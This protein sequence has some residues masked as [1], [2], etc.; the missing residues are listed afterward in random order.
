ML[1]FLDYETFSCVDIKAGVYAY[2]ECPTFEALMCAWAIDGGPVQVATGETEIAT[3]PGLFDPAV[4]KVAHNAQFER[5]VTSRLAGGTFLSPAAWFDTAALAAE[6]GYSRALAPL[7]KVLGCV[8]KDT[9]GTRLINR[10]CK[11]YR[12]G[13]VTAGDDPDRWAAFVDYCKQDVETLREVF[14]RLPPWPSGERELYNVD[15][16][17]NDRGITVDVALAKAAVT[18]DGR[19]RTA[20]RAELRQITGVV[21]PGS[22][23]Q[24]RGWFE[25]TGLPLSNLRAATVAE[26]LTDPGLSPEHRRALALRQHLALAASRKYEAAIRATNADGRFRGGFHFFGAHTGRWAGRG[27]QL[28]NLPR[29]EVSEGA[30][31]RLLTDGEATPEELKGL[32]RSLLVGPFTVV[33]YSAIE[34]RV[35]AWL[36]GESWVLE[37]FREDRDIYVATAERMSTPGNTLTRQQGKVATLALGYQGAVNSLRAMGA[38][39]ED[40][41]LVS[42]VRQWRRANPAIV[43]YW[44]AT[45]TR[46]ADKAATSQTV[47]MPLPSG[48][49][50]SYHGVRWET[51]PVLGSATGAK[52]WKEG[53]RYTDPR[54]PSSRAARVGTYGGRLVE[55]LTQAVARDILA[56]A[57]VRLDAAGFRV[58]GHVHD[59]VI[60][61]GDCLGE[62]RELMCRPL[63]WAEGLPL[64]AEGF[65]TDRYRKG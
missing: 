62:V 51:Y 45:A 44:S 20:Q 5:V 28:Q 34:A 32:I 13:R 55:N 16:R 50:I 11:P 30:V 42:L 10:F 9:A 37:A 2:T 33:D 47:R 53:W 7:A 14:Y 21:N 27:I 46:F 40:S 3:I 8:E 43:N 24:L 31:E 63:G 18:A 60:V 54:N 35:L 25:E 56:D 6:H 64:S 58:V 19:N 36:A 17:I 48:R 15:Q 4:M 65:V 22:T 1:L 39:G 59:E 52:V 41:E 49:H 23:Q 61:E 29:S 57:L 26:A 12:G 38:E